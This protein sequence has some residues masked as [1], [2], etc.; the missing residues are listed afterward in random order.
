MTSIWGLVLMS[1]FAFL[2]L[3]ICP[4]CV[5]VWSNIALGIGHLMVDYVI[6]LGYC[7]LL[8]MDTP[9]RA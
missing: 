8:P 1:E 6:N 4:V 3:S 5:R 9:L 7:L 2:A